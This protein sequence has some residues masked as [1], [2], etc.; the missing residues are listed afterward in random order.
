M[1]LQDVLL[2]LKQDYPQ[3][4]IIAEVRRRRLVDTIVEANELEL[5]LNGARRELLKALKDK[6]NRLTEA[7]EQAHGRLMLQSKTGHS[8]A[9][10][11]LP[12]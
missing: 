5:S 3:A 11:G 8:P 2:M 10:P 1:T 9:A 7:Q 6:R 12:K 4:A